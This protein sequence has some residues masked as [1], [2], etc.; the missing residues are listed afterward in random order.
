MDKLLPSAKGEGVLGGM[1]PFLPHY[2]QIIFCLDSHPY[3]SWSLEDLL[4]LKCEFW[5]N[6]ALAIHNLINFTVST[7]NLFR[8][9]RL[10]YV[11]VT[12][13]DFR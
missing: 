2:P 8:Q 4:Q 9:I 5:G 3:V 11:V 6:A 12:H 1:F 7:A 10:A 13:V